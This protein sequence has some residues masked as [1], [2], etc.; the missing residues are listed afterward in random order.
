[1]IIE[2]ITAISLLNFYHRQSTEL[3]VLK[4]INSRR[5]KVASE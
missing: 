3:R 1:M 4:G 2:H 5:G